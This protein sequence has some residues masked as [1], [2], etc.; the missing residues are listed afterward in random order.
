MIDKSFNIQDLLK[1]RNINTTLPTK[2]AGSE[3]NKT[4][5]RVKQNRITIEHVRDIDDK[6][7]LE[8]IVYTSNMLISY[9]D[10]A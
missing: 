9:T 1:E 7:M 10:L 3:N 5:Y 8:K 4:V 6:E 2:L